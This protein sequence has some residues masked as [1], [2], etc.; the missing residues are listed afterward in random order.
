MS[1]GVG[2]GWWL[3]GD[4]LGQRRFVELFRASPLELEGGG[5]FGPIT[6]AYESWGA[7]HRG[8]SNAILLLHGLTGD[9]HAA[10]TV[11]PGHPTSGWWEGL[12]GPGLAID[13]N[14]FQVICPN[15]FG[16][17]QGTTGPAWPA[18]DGVP[19][20][21]RF[22]GLTIRD[23]VAVEI[24]LADALGIRRWHAVIGGSMG[25][26]RA[27]EWAVTAP[28]RVEKLVVL[29][30]S[31]YATAEQIALQTAQIAAIRLDPQFHGGDYYLRG[32]VPWRGLALARSIGQVT[33][34]SELELESRFHRHPQGDQDPLRG[35]RYAVQSYLEHHGEKLVHRFDA[36]SYVVLSQAMNHHD[37]GR[38]R[39]GV[40][41]ALGRV[42][43]STWVVSV[44]T[45]R[46]Y[47]RRLQLQIAEATGSRARLED[48]GSRHGHDGFLLE[49]DQLTPLLRQALV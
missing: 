25:A 34:R 48:L 14:R 39:G 3:P 30:G 6:V 21:S 35:G 41:E 12:I 5:G 2:R 40:I 8:G 1:A 11:E 19:W 10:G 27:L 9:S 45:D 23:L 16:G 29:A 18:A 26:M 7:L 37:V 47:P 4:P 17:C 33:Y 13:T 43:A 20:G 22:P 28:E 44:G 31:A 36:N 49:R 38:G 24:A 42:T 15:A 46:L 32:E